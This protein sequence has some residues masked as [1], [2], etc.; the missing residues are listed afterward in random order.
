MRT[1]NKIAIV[2]IVFIFFML[3]INIFSYALDN[4]DFYKPNAVSDEDNNTVGRI[5]GDI[6]GYIRM[7]GAIL[8]VIILTIIGI[9]YILSSV[10]GKANYKEHM[11]PYIIGIF[12]IAGTT[13]LPSMIWNIA[14]NKSAQA[15][16]AA[17]DPGDSSIIYVCTNCGYY[18]SEGDTKCPACGAELEDY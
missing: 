13:M 11:V 4:T 16:K 10:E 9:K 2:L 12:L 8:S 7:F 6:L 18:L 3:F 17:V 15:K 5:T 14:N 1:I